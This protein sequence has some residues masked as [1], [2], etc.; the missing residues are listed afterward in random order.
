MKK[1][2]SHLQDS[3]KYII[4]FDVYNEADI[5]ITHNYK[6]GTFTKIFDTKNN[7]VEYEHYFP[8]GELIT[9]ICSDNVRNFSVTKK[10][11]D[12]Y[13]E[14]KQSVL[15]IIDSYG[16]AF[17]NIAQSIKKYCVYCDVTIT[18]YPT[19]HKMIKNNSV[20]I[21]KE[22]NHIIFFWYGGQNMEILDYFYNNKNF[23]DIT[24]CGK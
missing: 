20:T 21:G 1:Y 15:L 2:I 16:W 8:S 11:N 19:L 7:V 24:A 3:C 23:Y 5:L 18:T 10:I 17:D 13:L 14:N 6:Y 22:L 4:S 9:E 12:A